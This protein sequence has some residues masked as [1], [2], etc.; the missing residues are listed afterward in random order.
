MTGTEAT[1]NGNLRR[2]V[3]DMNVIGRSE[4][5]KDRIVDQKAGH[6]S[7]VQAQIFEIGP[8]DVGLELALIMIRYADHDLWREGRIVR[9]KPARDRRAI[10][11]VDVELHR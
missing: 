9:H 1:K 6:A 8:K 2:C 5:R 10:V 7:R 11:L 4:A 3:A